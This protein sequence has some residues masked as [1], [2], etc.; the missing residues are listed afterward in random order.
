MTPLLWQNALKIWVK[1]LESIKYEAIL[2]KSFA[3]HLHHFY[4]IALDFLEAE[5]P[6]ILIMNFWEMLH[7]LLIIAFTFC[8]RSESMALAEYAKCGLVLN[9]FG[10][11]FIYICEWW[12][13]KL[14]DI[15]LQATKLFYFCTYKISRKKTESVNK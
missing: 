11:T 7:I 3:D 9:G 4:I 10:F 15:I 1:I 12:K 14:Q 8:G 5:K 6:L 13:S 2:R